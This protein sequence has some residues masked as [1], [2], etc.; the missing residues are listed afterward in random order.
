M[1]LTPS[2]TLAAYLA[3]WT[4]VDL[5]EQV[6]DGL[7]TAT[8]RKAYVGQVANHVVG[9]LG[10]VTL[11][12]LNAARIRQWQTWLRAHGHSAYTR[13][14]A[15]SVL[16]KA[17]KYELIQ[18]ATSSAGADA[19]L[20]PDRGPQPAIST[21]VA[22]VATTAQMAI[23]VTVTTTPTVAKAFRTPAAPLLRPWNLG[24]PRYRYAAR[25]VRAEVLPC[26]PAQA[27]SQVM[28]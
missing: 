12:D 23:L 14:A 11:R 22:A 9:H 4:D 6:E 28:L 1:Q 2:I 13:K 18:S 27:M 3:W 21:A 15:L 7:I 25:P 24:E 10:A 5:V 8:T 19:E 26:S 20:T 17:W 16:K